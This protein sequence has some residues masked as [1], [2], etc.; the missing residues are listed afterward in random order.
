MRLPDR[1]AMLR[2]ISETALPGRRAAR[3]AMLC[4]ALCS[5]IPAAMAQASAPASEER[6]IAASLYRFLGYIEWPPSAFA[7]ADSPYVIGVVGADDIVEELSRVAAGRSM[8]NRPVS[9]RKLLFG[10]PLNGTHVLF[11]GRAEKTRQRQLLRQAQAQPVLVVTES[12]GALAQGSMINF[13]LVDD[14]VRFE[15]ALDP[16]EKS[17]LKINSRMLSVAISVTKEP[18]P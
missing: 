13:R 8:N 6:V 15:V 7:R 10:D 14:R 9:V 1:F 11:I 16:I 17:G 3:M 2:W 18:L 5:L 4:L 12:E